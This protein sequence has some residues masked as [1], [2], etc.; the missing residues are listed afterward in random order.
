[1]RATNE[2]PR[3]PGILGPEFFLTRTE[4]GTIAEVKHY[5]IHLKCSK[6]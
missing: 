6:T 1:M 2:G 5:D 3:L 4:K